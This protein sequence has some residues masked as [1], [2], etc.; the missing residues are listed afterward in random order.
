MYY[1]FFENENSDHLSIVQSIDG[2]KPFE[3]DVI[4]QNKD[5]EAVKAFKKGFENGDRM[6]TDNH[7]HVVYNEVSWNFTF[8]NG[9]WKLHKMV[10]GLGIHEF[11]LGDDTEHVIVNPENS[12]ASIMSYTEDYR[13]G[14]YIPYENAEGLRLT[15]LPAKNV[16][17][18]IIFKSNNINELS[19]FCY[20]YFDRYYRNGKWR[21]PKQGDILT[22]DFPTK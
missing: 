21:E 1:A 11:A 12:T 9:K 5:I 10:D 4:F 14:C 2:S 22:R 6:V 7:I 16:K 13:Y 3:C 17:D 19:I 18:E 15:R 8:F 20:A